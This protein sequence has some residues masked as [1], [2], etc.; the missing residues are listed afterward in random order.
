MS[1]GVAWLDTPARTPK[2][3]QE[4]QLAKPMVSN[5]CRG[6][7]LE[8]EREQDFRQQSLDEFV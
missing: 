4:T 1:P 7:V 8:L 6:S 2:A 5:V 3:Q